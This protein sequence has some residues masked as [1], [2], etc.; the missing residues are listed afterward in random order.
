[1]KQDEL[2]FEDNILFPAVSQWKRP[3]LRL[4]QVYCELT[5]FYSM[6]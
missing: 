6:K 4:F 2:I 3:Q 1:M 5:P